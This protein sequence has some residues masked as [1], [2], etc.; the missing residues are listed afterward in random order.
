MIGSIADY[1]SS[2]LEAEGRGDADLVVRDFFEREKGPTDAYAT[3]GHYGEDGKY[4]RVR[5]FRRG[6]THD[7]NR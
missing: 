7:V 3:N 2:T 4:R 1:I 5:G 6:G